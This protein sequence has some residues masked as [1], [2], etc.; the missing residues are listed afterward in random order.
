M[1][2]NGSGKPNW[3]NIYKLGGAAALGAVF[4]A[5]VEILITFI[6]GGMEIQETVL[7]WFRL[8]QDNWF[9]GLRN[10]GLINIFLNSFAR[11]VQKPQTMPFV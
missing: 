2:L 10:L 4:M 6:P 3:N 8:F 1:S 5:V 11:N 7:D 9:L